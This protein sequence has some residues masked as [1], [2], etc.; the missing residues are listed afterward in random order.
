MASGFDSPKKITE[1]HMEF[2][3][4]QT[5]L[6]KT[7]ITTR[8]SLEETKLPQ[9][10]IQSSLPSIKGQLNQIKE[11]SHGDKDDTGKLDYRISFNESYDQ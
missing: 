5:P 10:A 8:K 9:Y 11:E 2:T 3:S 4:N 6:A 1:S 7:Y